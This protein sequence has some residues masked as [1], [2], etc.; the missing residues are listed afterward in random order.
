MFPR[1]GFVN[2]VLQNRPAAPP[3]RKA[4][5]TAAR[6]RP[7]MPAKRFRIFLALVATLVVAFATVPGRSRAADPV[8]INLITLPAD[9]SAVVYYAQD[10]GFFKAAGLDVHITPMTNSASIVA[11]LA[12]GGADIGNSAV[13]SAAQ[14]RAK[15]IPVR[16]IAPSGLVT[17]KEPTAELV[18]PK[19]SPIQKLPT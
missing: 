3:L 17:A 18:V 16:F 2:S 11:A 7:L 10:K 9:N 4:A 15:G 5:T 12:G 14:A 6:T 13:G 1:P 19:E 8:V